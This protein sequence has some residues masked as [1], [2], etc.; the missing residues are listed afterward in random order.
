MDNSLPE[1]NT[2]IVRIEKSL[3]PDQ[4][5]EKLRGLIERTK[6]SL[7]YGINL[8]LID[9]TTRY[10]NWVLSIP[11]NQRTQ[12]VLDLKVVTQELENSHFGLHDIKERIIE[13]LA[14]LKLVKSKSNSQAIRAP[15]LCFIGLAGTGKTSIASS[16]AKSMQRKFIRIPLGGMGSPLELRGQAQGTSNSDPGKI[17]K[18]LIRAESLNP[19]I[20]LDE[21]DRV[22]DS[23]RADIMGVLLELLDPEQNSSFTDNYIDYPVNLSEVVFI[24]TGNNTTNISTAVLDRLEPIEMPTY[25]DEEKINIAKNYMLKK[26]MES[27]GIDNSQL[28]VD[29]T[30]WPLIVR[31]LG[32]DSGIRSLERTIQTITRKVA[33]KIV[34]G[35]GESF[36]I[37][38]E[39]IKEYI[40]MY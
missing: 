28:S 32:F 16:I 23:A 40:S 20:L 27:S 21:I 14:I 5:K 37:T 34:Q 31:P 18:S 38:P 24:T 1:I 19:V 17:I 9:Q 2:L 6:L 7:K 36:H 4:L 26:T 39:N 3:V 8:A 11:W 35:E 33:K 22:S 30:V 25:S 13:Y 29:D 10:I 15:V 12:D